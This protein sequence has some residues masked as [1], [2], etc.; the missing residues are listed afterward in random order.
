MLGCV[1]VGLLR[2]HKSEAPLTTHLAG[3]AAL[4]SLTRRAI[5]LVVLIKVF[6]REKERVHILCVFFCAFR[7]WASRSSSFIFWTQLIFRS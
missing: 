7:D 3:H 5:L 1:S 6:E 2:G 4:K